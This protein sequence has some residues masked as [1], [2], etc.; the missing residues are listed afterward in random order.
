MFD[1][2]D[3]FIETEIPQDKVIISRTDLKGVITYANDTFADISGYR[4]D[5]L[6]GKPHN[7]LRHPDMPRSIYKN[8][9]DT[10]KEEKV[11]QGYVK[12][13]R[14]D[15]GYYWVYA[16]VSGVYKNGELV[17]Y[18]SL[19]S[20]VSKEKRVEMQK[21]YDSMRLEEEDNVRCVCYISATLYD[22]LNLLAKS[23]SVSLEEYLES[24][25]DAL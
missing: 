23:K 14:K 16:E 5:E 4:Q 19:R 12:N 21:L 18:K 8:L 2:F 10:L 13:L 7:I 15:G 20:W 17:E 22:K 9:W 25:I 11:W 24:L 1:T 6:I 3:M